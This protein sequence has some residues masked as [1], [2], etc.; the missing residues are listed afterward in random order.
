MDKAVLKR[1][2]VLPLIAV[3][4]GAWWAFGFYILAI[5]DGVVWSRTC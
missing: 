1:F 4:F 5:N 2:T 3:R